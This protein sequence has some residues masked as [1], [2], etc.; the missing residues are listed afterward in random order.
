ML[1]SETETAVVLRTAD[2]TV[3]V[4]KRDIEDR[5]LVQQSIMPTGLLDNLPEI[6][7]IEL[8]K[9]LTQPR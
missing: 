3:T 7:M 5:R 1:D 6:E 4:P 8:L 2:Q 9:F